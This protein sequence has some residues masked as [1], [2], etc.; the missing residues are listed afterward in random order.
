[1]NAAVVVLPIAKGLCSFSLIVGEVVGAAMVALIFD[2]FIQLRQVFLDSIN[3][4]SQ[5]RSLG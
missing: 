4:S 5:I 2:H 3:L 1:M